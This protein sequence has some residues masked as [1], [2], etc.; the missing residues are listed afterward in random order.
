VTAASAAGAAGPPRVLRSL[1]ALLFQGRGWFLIDEH[2]RAVPNVVVVSLEQGLQLVGTS[3]TAPGGPPTVTLVGR[4]NPLVDAVDVDVEGV[5]GDAVVEQ[6]AR[7]C[8]ERELWWMVRPSGGAAGRAHV[9]VVTGGRRTEFEAFVASLRRQFQLSAT[10]VDLR[11]GGRP[12]KALRPL[13]AP[14]RTGAHPL[15]GGRLGE[16]LAGLRAALAATPPPLLRADARKRRRP[17]SSSRPAL[18]HSRA[19]HLPTFPRRQLPADWSAHLL[20]GAPPP[21]RSRDRSTVELLATGA[22]VRA[23][24]SADSAWAVL[25]Q[26]PAGVAEKAKERGRFWWERYV[27]TAAERSSAAYRQSLATSPST[28]S[29]HSGPSFRPETPVKAPAVAIRRPSESQ[30]AVSAARDAL[31]VLQWRLTARE[32]HG[33]LLVAHTLLDRMY[34]V[35]ATIVP[36]PL[37]DLELDTGLSLPTISAALNRLDGLLG[38][39]VTH[40]FDPARRDTTS[41]TFALDRRFLD[42]LQQTQSVVAGGRVL[43]QP[44]TP[45]SH[46]PPRVPPLPPGAWARLGPRCATLWRTLLAHAGSSDG[47]STATPSSPDKRETEGL[48]LSQVA[49]RAGMTSDAHTQVT[50]SQGRTVRAHLTRLMSAGLVVVDVA[51]RWSATT[52]TDR[53]FVRAAAADHHHVAERVARERR[54]YRSGVGRRGALWRSGQRAALQ[55]Q[56]QVDLARQRRWWVHLDDDERARRTA[57]YAACFAAL[58]PHAQ[59]VAKDDWA[60]CR[61][62]QGADTERARHE[63][64]VAS[65]DPTAYQQRSIE[66]SFT[67]ALLPRPLQVELV[68]QWSQHRQT[69]DVPRGPTITTLAGFDQYGADQSRARRDQEFLAQQQNP[70]RQDQLPFDGSSSA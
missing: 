28:S 66:R 19:G 47:D 27:W 25:Q 32:R 53:E 6:L 68:R 22:L 48:P 38:R 51:G 13:S 58:P 33:V 11:G 34:R 37:R 2:N 4:L 24:H 52:A 62:Q 43:S 63:K 16:L 65:R 64:W 14:H 7:W 46:T 29:L 45:M 9:L 39:R 3:R 30:L 57:H 1:D 23:G 18:S 56:R 41:H 8:A 5:R 15:P 42:L 12:G 67:F 61:A 70:G 49:Q 69:W 35:D 26:T 10:A 54:D 17:Q 44:L 31:L 36:C 59:T 40:T 21:C 60:T 50:P 20:R 55:R